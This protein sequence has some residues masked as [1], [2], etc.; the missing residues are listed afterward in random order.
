MARSTIPGKE[1]EG[2]LRSLVR[3]VCVCVVVGK[4]ENVCVEEEERKRR[5][6]TGV[7]LA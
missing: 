2:A 1:A 5:G 3:Q 6:I 7:E 4:G